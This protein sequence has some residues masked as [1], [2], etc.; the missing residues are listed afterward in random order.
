MFVCS[1]NLNSATGNQNNQKQSK[2]K[3]K[4]DDDDDD[5]VSLNRLYYKKQKISKEGGALFASKTSN[6]F[7]K[8][9][10][11]VFLEEEQKKENLAR[12][13]SSTL[14]WMRR[15]RFTQ[16]QF[17]QLEIKDKDKIKNGR[18]KEIF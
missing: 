7:V 5:L 12:A 17:G 3:A 6:A 2:N 9:I 4:D 14:T 8:N 1:I 10:N 11:K 15:F 16:I 18:S 13:R